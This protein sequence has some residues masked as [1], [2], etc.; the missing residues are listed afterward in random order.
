MHADASDAFQRTA[1]GG[2]LL[3]DLLSSI[4]VD[5]L[6]Q[7]FQMSKIAP[8]QRF[9]NEGQFS[10]DELKEHAFAKYCSV[11]DSRPE[12]IASYIGRSKEVVESWAEEGN[13][14]IR[15]AESKKKRREGE[16]AEIAK[17]LA[18]AG[19]R[20]RRQS[21]VKQLALTQRIF[22][23]SAQGLADH[24]RAGV[25]PGTLERYAHAVERAQ[26]IQKEAY[27]QL[28]SG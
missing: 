23:L 18:E 9:R 7:G 27:S 1:F 25:D 13:W 20:D 8:F 12:R 15:R 2:I 4:L 16:L 19:V 21:A 6:S 10:D 26:K 3:C 14:A 17:L 11:T 24:G 28:S 22:D 5:R